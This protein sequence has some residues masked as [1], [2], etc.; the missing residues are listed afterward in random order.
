METGLDDEGNE[1]S[2][3][4]PPEEVIEEFKKEFKQSIHYK[5][6]ILIQRRVF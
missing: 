6:N 2:V 5:K 4:Y 1:V 3:S